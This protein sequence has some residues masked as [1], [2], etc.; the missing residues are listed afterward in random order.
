M[1]ERIKARIEIDAD[2]CWNWQGSVDTRGYGN[3]NVG[4]RMQRVHRVAYMLW[5]G[6][7]PKATGH[8][9]TVVMHACDNRRCCNPDH[10]RLGTQKDNVR[11]MEAKGRARHHAGTDN[12]RAIL[13]PEQVSA[14]RA[15][16]RSLSQI[17]ADYPVSLGAIQRI[18]A[19][20]AWACLPS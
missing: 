1:S 9:G 14:I 17:T 3:L 16:A 15:D 12:G 11:D 5:V 7:I 2:G 10:L 8:H 18:K 4:G 20:K 13:T 19:G 6:D